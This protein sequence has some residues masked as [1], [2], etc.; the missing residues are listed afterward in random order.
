MSLITDYTI[1]VQT[2]ANI[3]KAKFGTSYNA[4]CEN[5]CGRI[6][7]MPE[8]VRKKLS[9]PAF[10]RPDGYE[11]VEFKYNSSSDD[12]YNTLIFCSMCNKNIQ[13]DESEYMDL[14]V[15]ANLCKGVTSDGEQCK[16]RPISGILVCLSHKEQKFVKNY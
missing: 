7:Y 14:Q 5:Q 3:W 6:I 4:F 13:K 15:V 8:I 1:P 2:K 12:I 10:Q 16:M 9:L 11:S